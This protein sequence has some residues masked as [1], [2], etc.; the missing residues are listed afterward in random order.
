M[1]TKF[2]KSCIVALITSPLAFKAFIEKSKNVKYVMQFLNKLWPYNIRKKDKKS[3][4]KKMTFGKMLISALEMELKIGRSEFN[5]KT[6]YFLLSNENIL[7]KSSKS[8][9]IQK[10][11]KLNGINAKKVISDLH[12][13]CMLRKNSKQIIYENANSILDIGVISKK[14]HGGISV[15]FLFGI[16]GGIELEYSSTF[17]KLANKNF[18]S[19]I[20][21]EIKSHGMAMHRK[22][23]ILQVIE[24]IKFDAKMSS[25]RCYNGQNIG[26]EFEYSGVWHGKMEKEL[27]RKGAISFNSGFDGDETNG[28]TD[29]EFN[30]RL[31]ENRLRINGLAGIN[32]L[33]SLVEQMSLDS[34]ITTSSGLHVHVDVGFRNKI[35]YRYEIRSILSRM[36]LI[37]AKELADIY[38]IKCKDSYE[39]RAEFVRKNFFSDLK[40]S[41]E[42]DTIEFR[43]LYP[44]FDYQLVMIQILASLHI[45]NSIINKYKNEDL[46]KQLNIDYLR[47][48]AEKSI[49]RKKLI[50]NC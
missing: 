5:T 15:D 41:D 10:G 20:G 8:E 6:R 45:V 3:D 16:Y 21:F 31:R 50:D 2:Q 35:K 42:F 9:V 37:V 26:I 14:A 32:A 4:S 34:K 7:R 12:I 48:L 1:L 25:R 40:M 22:A 19:I 36:S 38:L 13:M 29:E 23:A 33:Y 46:D 11:E 44:T 24:M 27:I 43:M 49:E 30:D 18:I 39:E 28:N 17:I 47:F